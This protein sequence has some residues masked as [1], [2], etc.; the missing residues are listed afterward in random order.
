MIRST[1]RYWLFFENR[2]HRNYFIRRYFYGPALSAASWLLYGLRFLIPV[3][4]YRLTAPVFV[5]GCSRS[6]TTIFI[7]H[8]G[9]HPQVC[10][11]SE[12][13]QITELD[14][15]NPEIEHLKE[16]NPT[17]FEAFRVRFWFGVRTVLTGCRVFV[18]KHPENSL[19]MLW[20]RQIFP[21]ARFLHVIREG[22]AVTASN[23]VRT[24]KDP[25]R[26][27][28]PFG[29]FPKPPHWRKYLNLQ[30]PVQF[31]HQWVDITR[32]IREVG[33]KGLDGRDYLEIR[34]EAF[35]DQPALVLEQ[36]DRFAGIDPEVRPG[37]G[38]G[39][40]LK[41]RNYKWRELFDNDQVRVIAE[42]L[43]PLDM[44]LG[45]GDPRVKTTG[46]MVN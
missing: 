42:I 35:C 9:Q 6:G 3:A 37:K 43:G 29:Q 2:W 28:W 20:L 7:E 18:N 15:Y 10:N 21:D 32:Y 19:R 1:M 38:D 41:S 46:E 23:Y 31:A 36:V 12:A 45:Y 26:T 11:W 44:E 27:N 13:A 39:I 14:F 30:L 17:G 16:W 5:V 40:D 25:F 24:M 22:M 8:F 34:Y 33:A 4:L